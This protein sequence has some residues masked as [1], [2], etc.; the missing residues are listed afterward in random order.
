M[1]RSVIW[2]LLLLVAF[3]AISLQGYSQTH[4]DSLTNLLQKSGSDTN[5]I[6]LLNELAD[7]FSKSEMEVATRYADEAMRLS[8]NIDYQKGIAHSINQ[9]GI[10]EFYRGNLDEAEKLFELSIE[11]CKKASLDKYLALVLNNVGLVY[12]GAEDYETALSYF[13]QSAELMKALERPLGLANSLNNIGKLFYD[14]KKYEKALNY[15]ERAQTLFN[16][17]DDKMGM[18]TS[19]NNIGIIYSANKDFK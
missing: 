9:K 8:V 3:S 18:S 16:S 15:Y 13:I 12:H 5:R 7:K 2:F 4:V 1:H 11:T 14:Q 19:F 17:V 10:I 6:R